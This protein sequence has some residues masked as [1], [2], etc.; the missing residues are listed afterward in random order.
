MLVSGNRFVLL[1]DVGTEERGKGG[2]GDLETVEHGK[3]GF[4]SKRGPKVKWQN[5]LTNSSKE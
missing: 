1:T 5:Y 2:K 3:G 4:K